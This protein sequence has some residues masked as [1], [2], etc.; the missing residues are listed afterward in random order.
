MGELVVLVGS[1][2]L[3]LRVMELHGCSVDHDCRWLARV[4]LLLLLLLAGWIVSCRRRLDAVG[5]AD[6]A[7]AAATASAA[8]RWVVAGEADAGGDRM[9]MICF[10]L[11]V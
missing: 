7:A 1:V 11:L 9:M 8:V 2:R 6:A 5:N 10:L 3:G 4:L